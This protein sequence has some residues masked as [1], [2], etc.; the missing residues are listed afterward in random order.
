MTDNNVKRDS[1]YIESKLTS[2]QSLS[3]V[4]LF[5]TPWACNTLLPCPSPTL[6]A[7]SNSCPFSDAIQPS[8][9]LLSPSP[10][11]N[12]SQHQGIFQ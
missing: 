7:W 1:E 4:P 9:P 12:L 8:H 2:V 11:F 6:G 10:V 3:H 5:A